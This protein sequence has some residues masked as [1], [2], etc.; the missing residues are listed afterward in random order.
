MNRNHRRTQPAVRT[1]IIVRNEGTVF[2]F[3]PLTSAAKSMDS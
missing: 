3:C 2:L 1:D